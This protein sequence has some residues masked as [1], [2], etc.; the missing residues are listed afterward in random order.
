MLLLQIRCK[1]GT[2]TVCSQQPQR[3][4]KQTVKPGDKNAAV[5]R[6]SLEFVYHVA[7]MLPITPAQLIRP[8]IGRNASCAVSDGVTSRPVL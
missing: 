1:I 5:S 2:F 3:V 7:R 8:G 4:S 6:V